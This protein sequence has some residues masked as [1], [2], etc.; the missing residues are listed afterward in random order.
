MDD[1]QIEDLVY[2]L[3]RY[4]KTVDTH[5][6]LPLRTCQFKRVVG[7]LEFELVDLRM[8]EE[9]HTSKRDIALYLAHVDI[10]SGGWHKS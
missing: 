8:S 7:E 4:A 6:S 5:R 10:A 9:I 3:I 1:F 2:R